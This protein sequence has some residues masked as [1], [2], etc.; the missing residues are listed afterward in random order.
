MDSSKDVKTGSLELGKGRPR[1]Y[2]APIVIFLSAALLLVVAWLLWITHNLKA[3]GA[4]ITLVG[5]VTGHFIK[6]VQELLGSWRKG[7]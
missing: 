2:D 6:E 5:V 4:A 3:Q 7:Q 1:K